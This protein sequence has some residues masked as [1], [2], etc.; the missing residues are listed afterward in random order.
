MCVYMNNIGLVKTA[1]NYFICINDNV[2]KL[3]FMQSVKL[4]TEDIER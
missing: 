3:A 1:C 4:S 2:E